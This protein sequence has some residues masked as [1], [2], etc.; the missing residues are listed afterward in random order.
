[1]FEIKHLKTLASLN[2]T[3]S[4]RKTAEALFTSQSALSHQIKDLEQRLNKPLFIRNTSPVQFT[5]HGQILL[6]LADEV[7]PKTDAALKQLIAINKG[8]GVLNLA[9]ECHACF[10][11]LLPLTEQFSQQFPQLKLNFL[12]QVFSNQ[13]EQKTTKIDMLFTDEKQDDDSYIYHAIGQFEVLAVLAKHNNLTREDFVIAADFNQ[14]TLLTYPVKIESL[15]IFK[16]FL[17]KE[18]TSKQKTSKEKAKHIFKAIKQVA[19]SHMILQMVAADMGIAT[20]PDW[21][22][23]SL[24]KQSLVQ[25]KRIG[26]VGIHK[27]IYARYLQKNE[28]FEVIEK[29]IPQIITAFECLYHREVIGK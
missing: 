29:L 4:M 11:W 10:Q 2:I 27:I 23:N 8:K 9:I 1:M 3:G 14:Q 21:L 26:K 17:N 28:H 24:A 13:N 15:D 20:L 5:E 6:Q 7:L 12:E 22:V 25:T 19:N 16:L 18:A